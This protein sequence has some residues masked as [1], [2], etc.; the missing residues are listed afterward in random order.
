MFMLSL[1]KVLRSV[2]SISGKVT[3]SE[4]RRCLGDFENVDSSW[5]FLVMFLTP[6]FLLIV[7]S[8]QCDAKFMDKETA[9]L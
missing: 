9:S 2:S 6:Q 1:V 7:F 3:C 4:R 8:I 5:L